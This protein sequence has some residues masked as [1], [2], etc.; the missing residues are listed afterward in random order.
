VGR[1]WNGGLLFQF[2]DSVEVIRGNGR[3]LSNA[4]YA[5]RSALS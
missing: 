1:T 5:K 2:E 3:Q 4:A